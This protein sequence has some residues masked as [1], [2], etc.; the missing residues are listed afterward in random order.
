MKNKMTD[1]HNHLFMALERLNEEDRK[2]EELAEEIRRSETICK[3]AGQIISN[4]N[5]VL[6]AKVAAE[7]AG[8][9]LKLPL[10]LE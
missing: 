6:R 4:G 3:V 2:G 9:N 1:L 7:N 10:L 8:G 5:L